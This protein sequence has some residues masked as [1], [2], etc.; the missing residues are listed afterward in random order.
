MTVTFTEQY[1]N[2]VNR[3]GWARG[4]WDGELDKAVW[5]HDGVDCM[6]KRNTV[7]AWC[8]YIG[9]KKGHPLFNKQYHCILTGDTDINGGLTYSDECNGD[10]CH[11]SD[12]GDHVWW[13]GFDCS[14]G[15]NDYPE[16][17]RW[18]GYACDYEGYITQE[19]AINMVNN[20]AEDVD[21][22]GLWEEDNEDDD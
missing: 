16:Q 12:D 10:I 15:F 2:L 3:N 11:L 18:G 7:G 5:V 1:N 4:P 9:V 17:I 21:T 20:M 6:I 13:F 14:H 22:W 8:G 19:E